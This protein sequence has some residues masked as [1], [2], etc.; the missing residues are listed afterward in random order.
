VVAR[1]V[2]TGT[3]KEMVAFFQKADKK[4]SDALERGQRALAREDASGARAIFEEALKSPIPDAATRTRILNGYMEA[5]SGLDPAA[6]AKVGLE[7]I[8]DVENT[9][10]G[11]DFVAMVESC[12]SGLDSETKKTVMNAVITRLLPIAAD[13]KAPLEV[14][15]RSGVYEGLTEAYEALGRKDDARRMVEARARLLDQAAKKATTIAERS[16]FNAHRLECDLKLG[17]YAEAE[18]MLQESESAQP[19]DYNHP[20]RLAVLYLKWN[21]PDEGLAAIDR[22]LPLGY[23]PRKLRLY[24]TKVDL[25]LLKKHYAEARQTVATAKEE[26]KSMPP[27]QVRPS[28]VKELDSKL[29]TIAILEKSSS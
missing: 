20:W 3:A 22:A 24:A 2:G 27:K 21:K 10:P 12:A 19:D 13:A 11:M 15:D 14:D 9:A 26:I 25:L 28:S 7:H 4:T 17:R 8:R 18:K 5:L 29:E 6:C 16:T 23:G 1:W